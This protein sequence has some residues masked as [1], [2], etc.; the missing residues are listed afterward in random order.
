MRQEDIDQHRR[1]L[2]AMLE[3][4]DEGTLGAA[5]YAGVIDGEFGGGAI[6]GRTD[7]FDVSAV[8]GLADL[9]KAHLLNV[10]NARTSNST[11]PPTGAEDEKADG[12]AG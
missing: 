2:E 4:L 9:Q 1:N 8:I 11:E 3:A 12:S 5:I 6:E 7:A 10:L